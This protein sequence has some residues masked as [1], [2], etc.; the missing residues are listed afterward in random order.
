MISTYA[1]LNEKLAAAFSAISPG[2]D[3][4]LR[5]SDHGDYQANGVMALAKALG[6]PPRDVA[7]DVLARLDLEGVANVEI[8]GPGFLNLTL[9]PEFLAR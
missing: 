7:V 3:P 1:Q 6:R 4:V 5:T 9:T 2:S 8:A